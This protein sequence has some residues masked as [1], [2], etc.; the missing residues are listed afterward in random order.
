MKIAISSLFPHLGSFMLAFWAIS[1]LALRYC[2]VRRQG[3]PG[4]MG[5]IVAVGTISA[6]ACF[7]PL[8]GGLSLSNYFLSFVPWVSAGTL[9]LVTTSLLALWRKKDPLTPKERLALQ[10]TGLTYGLL[11][12][13]SALG[14]MPWDL[15][16][17]GYGQSWLMAA[18]FTATVA[19]AASG[20]TLALWPIAAAALWLAGALPSGNIH[21]C[22]TDALLPMLCAA[23]IIKDRV[24]GK[25]HKRQA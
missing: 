3:G 24:R 1:A 23:R 8:K 15:Y 14:F 22:L 21:D 16:A 19:T 5:G 7:T 13:L 4:N 11:L 17:A 18:L 10:W 12:L 20:S 9:F 6:I 2:L 25:R